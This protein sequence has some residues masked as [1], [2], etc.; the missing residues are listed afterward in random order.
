MDG[1][2][3]ADWV[4]E[5][6]SSIDFGDTRLDRRLKTSVTAFSK[7]GES[8]PENCLEAGELKGMYRLVNNTK[9][10]CQQILKEHENSA[11]QRCRREK[12]VYVLSDSSEIDLT[13]PKIVVEGAGPIGA[14]TRRGFYFHP[15]YAVNA[16]GTALGM[17]D[18]VIW[19]RSFDSLQRSAEEKRSLRSEACFEE[20]ETWRWLEIQQNNEQLARSM[21]STHF[22]M[23]ADSEADISELLSESGEFPD[24]F[25][26]IIRGCHNHRID[27]TQSLAQQTTT[28]PVVKEGHNLK[29][30]NALR[31]A[32][33]RFIL[34]VEVPSKPAPVTP[35]DKKR[36]RRQQRSA[37][38]AILSVRAMRLTLSA[39]SRPGGTSLKPSTLNVVELLEENP[40]E[41]DVPIHWVLFTTLP[42]DTDEDLKAVIDGYTKRWMVE[43]FFKTLK[44][45]LK[46]EG[47]KYRKLKGYLAAFA[48]S[49]VVAWRI[50]YLKTAARND[51]QASCSKYCSQHEWI[52][53]VTFLEKKKPDLQNP[54]TISEFVLMVAR[55]G[56]YINKKAQG[57]PGSRTIWR[58][59]KRMSAIVQAYEIFSDVRCGV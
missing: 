51:P 53:V 5:E 2:M 29:V 44:S 58:G 3:I 49:S 45:G 59:M 13:K 26:I 16:E 36:K 25:D 12:K 57:P 33:V 50:E 27:D 47:M 31:V 35:D 21:P 17:I 18:H 39:I 8:T 34:P 23:V 6:F 24:N 55:L 10:D 43:L 32:P 14:G 52:S 54:P 7:V 20:K 46:V 56:G 38:T 37:H 40:P 15:S 28:T 42:I 30:D 22:I 1:T 41:S 48:V 9:V 19:S 11:I 4:A